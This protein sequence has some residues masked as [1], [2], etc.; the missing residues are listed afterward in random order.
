MQS[1]F[2]TLLRA[3]EGSGKDPQS[4]PRCLYEKDDCGAQYHDQKPGTLAR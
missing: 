1:G 3:S 2:Q 4:R